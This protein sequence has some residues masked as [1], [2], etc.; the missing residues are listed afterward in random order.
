[1]EAQSKLLTQT[2]EIKKVT[3]SLAD[4]AAKAE[5]SEDEIN[6]YYTQNPDKYT[7][8]EQVKLSYIE[9][10]AQQLKDAIEIS[11]QQ[12]EEYYQQH[13]DKYSS[14][15]QRRVS[16]ILVE[17]DDKAKAQTIL[18]KVNSGGDFAALAEESSDDIG[19]AS[20]GGS[21]GWIE[22][23]VMDPA[24][25]KAA[26]ALKKV[27]D[28]TGLVKSDFG[29]H[30]INWMSSRALLLSLIKSLAEDIKQE[31]QDQESIDQFARF[32]QIEK[33]AFEYPD[34]L[35]DAAKTSTLR[36]IPLILSLNRMF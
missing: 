27:G 4:F 16:H 14:E 18:D 19:S 34:A 21:L 22:R 15:E 3:L 1:M 7:R 28:V 5:L 12:A 31:L 17:G 6:D 24:F 13:L 20:E 25:E 11:D 9:L 2:R 8:P 33:V 36:F 23:D 26:F 29:Y 10:S 32:E 30:I 35:D